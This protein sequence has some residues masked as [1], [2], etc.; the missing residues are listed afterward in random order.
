MA[1]IRTDENKLSFRLRARD[2][3]AAALLST[4]A[5]VPAAAQ[6]APPPA[7]DAESI[8]V[9]GTSIRGTASVGSNL[10]TLDQQEIKNT[11]AQ[12]VAQIFADMPAIESMGTAGRAAASQSNGGPGTAIYIHQLGANGSNS[13]LVL[14]DGHRLPW[15]G[16]TNYFVDPNNVPAAMI[17]R[18]EVLAEGASAVYGSD[19]VAGVV[20]FITRSR[21]EGLEFKT[22]GSYAPGTHTFQASLMGGK[23]WSTGWIEGAI[24]FVTES[25]LRD[26]SR[27]WTNPLA[28]PARAAAAGL[29]GPGATN[30]GNFNCDPA[31]IRPNAT[32]TVIYPNAQTATPTTTASANQFCTNWQYGAILPDADREN[33]MIKF[34]QE[35]TSALTLTADAVY[36]QRSTKQIQS[37]GT[38][39]A[40]A[41]GNGFVNPLLAPTAL[42]PTYTT[43]GQ[44]NP[45]YTNPPGQAALQKQE[46]RYDFDPLLGPGAVSLG[47][48]NDMHASANLAYSLGDD[49]EVDALAVVGRDDDF[50]GQNVGTVNTATALLALNG[51]TNSAGNV[52]QSS[53]P[54]YNSVTLN[55]PLTAANALDVW[56]PAAT[57]RTSAATLASLTNNENIT[58]GIYSIEE[59][60]FSAQGSV[61]SLPAGKLKVA[62][63]IEQL[64]TQIY[65]FGTRP[66]NNAGA[67]VGSQ[68]F[69]YRFHRQDTAEFIEANIPVLAPD[70]QIPL[71]SKFDVDLALRRDAYSDFGDTTNYKASFNWDVDWGLRLRGNISTSFVA[72][73]LNL[74][75]GKTGLA[76]FSS[77][78]AS[79][80]GGAI[81]PAAYPLV[82]NF[83]IA[84][85][86]AASASCSITSLN[87][88]NISIGDATAIAQH[89]HGWSIGADFAPD[90]IP[91]LY[92]AITLWNTTLIGGMTAPQFGA[93]VTTASLQHD[94]TLYPNCA[95]PA[96][97]TAFVGST[98]QTAVF[99]ACVQFT[100]LS[101]TSNYLSFYAQGL[102]VEAQY[103]FTTDFGDFVIGDTL[104]QMLKFDEGFAYKMAPTP[105]QTF[106]ALGTDGFASAF[107]SVATQMRT[108][109]GWS[110][111]DFMA[112]FYMNY[113]SAYRN[114][115]GTAV[116]APVTNAA[117]VYSG[118]GGDHVSAN[119][120]FDVHFA[121]NFDGGIFGGDQISLIV[122]NVT[123]ERPPYF[124][125]AN[126]YDN[127]LANPIGRNVLLGLSAKL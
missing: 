74:V 47:G 119:V 13:T 17:E 121:Y 90:Y 61:L 5:I 115:N 106:S 37:R 48:D 39:T 111:S 89:G 105:D 7:S 18:I 51:T 124:N 50:A 117:G 16:V 62:F 33:A 83:G 28:Q 70:M 123:N 92:T 54:G 103:R 107:P 14:M 81:S 44:N 35:I 45:F 12:N 60:R 53:V 108:H 42:N 100:F 43:T 68:L 52:Q 80:G 32:G 58:H 76:N 10:I 66:E 75:G 41:F 79:T 126:G 78:S 104:T 2:G 34:S 6:P 73:P 91:G 29:S 65:E 86:T 11:G 84:G 64:N 85:C 1:R 31:A 72:P 30:F 46:I 93:R 113:T 3:V 122:Q 114:V 67:N 63:G 24:G 77:A 25:Q 125:S 49:W 120:T 94:L 8:V 109:L 36:S 69:Q 110:L 127:L 98:P 116:V 40:T 21:F 71:V 82:T 22:Q 19:A 96:Q 97:I 55:V 102:D 95:T 15:S 38:L 20:N 56:N 57:N 23:A 112:D 26:T 9:T 118:Q 88:I 99:P 27:P 101:D 4:T 87:G 59:G